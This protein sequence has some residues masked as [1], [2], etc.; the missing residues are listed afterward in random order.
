MWKT[1]Q[2]FLGVF[3]QYATGGVNFATESYGG[4]FFSLRFLRM[5]VWVIL[6]ARSSVVFF[7]SFLP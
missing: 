4:E 7:F 1:L 5:G 2:G 3:P 6:D